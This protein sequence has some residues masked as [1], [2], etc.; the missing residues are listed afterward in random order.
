MA[1]SKFVVLRSGSYGQKG[2]VIALDTNELTERQKVM[3]KPYEAPKVKGE[4]D[5]E[6]DVKKLKAEIK[7]LKAENKQLKAD[8]EEITK[9]AET[10][11]DKAK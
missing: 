3:L 10:E 8:L 2:D 6:A 11:S 5:G 1:K 9:P 4:E 7:K